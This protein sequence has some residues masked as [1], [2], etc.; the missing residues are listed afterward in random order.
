MDRKSKHV[1]SDRKSATQIRI[2]VF[3]VLL[4]KAG[5]GTLVA[6]FWRKFLEIAM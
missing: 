1:K 3:M 5:M 4:Y 2:I 6:E